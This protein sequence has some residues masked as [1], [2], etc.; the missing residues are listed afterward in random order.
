MM[1][2]KMDIRQNEKGQSLVMLLL[3]M[4]AFF[5]ILALVIDGG[6][7]YFQRRN[8]QNAADAGALAGA[9][10]YCEYKD[11]LQASGTASSY[12]ISNEATL[13]EPVT[14][15]ASQGKV[16]VKTQINYS[17]F[18]GNVINQSSITTVAEAEAGCQ[19]PCIGD[20]VL[21][22]VW[23]C[24]PG[25]VGS[26]PGATSCEFLP[27]DNDKLQRYLND[28]PEPGDNCQTVTLKGESYLLCPELTVIMDNIDVDTL[29]C[30]SVGGLV[31]CDF[32]GDGSDDY[33]S[34]DNRGWADLDGNTAAYQCDPNGDN[35]G[36]GVTEL[37]YW[38]T[39]GYDCPFSIHTWVGD[40][41]G[42]AVSSFQ[43]VE[44]RRKTNPIVVLPIFDDSCPGDPE[45]TS[46]CTWHTGPRPPDGSGDLTHNFTSTPN[47]YHIIRFSAF[48]ITCVQTKKDDCPGAQ[49]F[50][51]HNEALIKSTPG[52]GVDYNA[53]EGYFLKGY[54]P[55]LQSSCGY[56]PDMDVFSVYLD[57]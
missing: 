7:T 45:T 9:R 18:V 3:L 48:Y 14:I 8:A 25:A 15:N 23:T 29:Q 20:G 32:D 36:E 4:F 30:Q 10:D 40:Q 55:G 11:A 44:D 54:V 35:G 41:S 49:T 37:Q 13:Y 56:D 34:A 51:D 21:P 28:N 53:I 17:T 42:V 27:I 52:V 5:V 31:D 16:N 38:I 46:E 1:K 26:P 33:V 43:E 12:V 22:V 47:Y 50:F 57:K 2:D 24:K 6:N 19:Q 39:N